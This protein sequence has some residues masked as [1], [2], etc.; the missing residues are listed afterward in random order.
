MG[1]YGCLLRYL[2]TLGSDLCFAEL[3]LELNLNIVAGELK[4]VFYTLQMSPL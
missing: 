1:F 3:E 4:P 2:G